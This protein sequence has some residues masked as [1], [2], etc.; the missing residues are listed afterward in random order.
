MTLLPI[1]PCRLMI[2]YINNSVRLFCTASWDTHNP[3]N[4]LLKLHRLGIPPLR[5]YE[6]W[7]VA[8]ELTS[9]PSDDFPALD[10]PLLTC[11]ILSPHFNSVPVS[12]LFVVSIVWWRVLFVCL[13]S[14]K[15]ILWEKSYG[16][17]AFADC[18]HLLSN[19]YLRWSTSSYGVITHL[20]LSIKIPL[21]I[22][23][24]LFIYH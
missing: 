23:L 18:L 7:Q 2:T 1:I 21:Y 20:F 10:F 5:I 15:L 14:F 16:T 12:D 11:L 3:L 13:F 17:A 22:C 6:F 9:F 24:L 4:R 19:A 8:S